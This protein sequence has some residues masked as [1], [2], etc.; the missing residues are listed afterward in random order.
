YNAPHAPM[1]A[2]EDDLA[3]N[4]HIKNQKRRVVAG[5][6]TAVDRGVGLVTDAL[7]K[8]GRFENTLVVFLSD[9][10][11][12]SVF[13][14]SNAPFRGVKGDTWEGGFRVPMFFHWPE[15][16]PAQKF[17]FPVSSLD[18]YPTFAAV[19]DAKI[20]SN[21][22]LDGVN[23]LSSLVQGNNPR[24]NEVI[25][26][27]RHRGGYTDVSARRGDW[28]AVRHS[29]QPWRLFNITEDLSEEHDLASSNPE[30]LEE[31][32]A[33]AERWSQTHETPLFFDSPG[34]RDK[35]F[36][37]NMPHFDKT[38]AT[39]VGAPKLRPVSH[40]TD[41]NIA[42]PVVKAPRTTE[43]GVKLK[44]GD[45][46]IEHFVAL[47]KAKWKKNG[48]TWNQQ[49]AEAIFQK[50]DTNSDGIASGKEKK[51]YWSK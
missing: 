34:A 8:R 23:L 6:M 48:W 29:N 19:A 24:P 10:G 21:K 38:F 27:M 18:F 2:T 28:K 39:E 4:A 41:S 12:K 1:E 7:K 43:S 30:R 9:N 49:K 13:G 15:K 36:G 20:P 47:E 42:E 14:S 3:A 16:I 31:L 51:A 32:I 40:V 22:Q 50:I 5:M 35:W 25:F 26:A 45:S 37:T 46:T 33:A 17:D 11:G 44:R